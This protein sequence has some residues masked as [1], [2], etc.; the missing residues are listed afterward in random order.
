MTQYPSPPD[1]AREIV[2]RDFSYLSE[3]GPRE[4]LAQLEQMSTPLVPFGDLSSETLGDGE[5]RFAY[6]GPPT[7]ELIERPE[8]GERYRRV[9][10]IQT[11]ALLVQLDAPDDVIW[12][13]FRKQLQDARRHYPAPV[14]KPGRKAMNARF[15]ARKFATWRAHKI[16][17][18]HALMTWRGEISEAERSKY[19]QA[20]LGHWL[21]FE[22]K[23]TSEAVGHLREAL[24]A[25]PALR[26]QVVEEARAPKENRK[27]ETR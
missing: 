16:V 20:A 7:V 12:R 27:G 1:G 9:Y 18:L 17:T 14:K 6:L 2:E 5:W 19:P 23:K 22:E 26:A 24:K 3:F 11:P 13:E 21:E 10:A 15:D 4:W 8:N 25:I